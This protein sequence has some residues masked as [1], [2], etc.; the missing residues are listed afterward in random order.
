MIRKILLLALV[1]LIAIQFFHPAKN[2]SPDIAAN[3]IRHAYSVP[4]DVQAIFKKAC[5][6]CHSNNTRYP[7]YYNIQPVA[8][9]IK[10]HVDEGREELDF[11]EFAAYKPKKQHHKLEEL[12]EQ[13]KEEEMPLPSY[14]WIHRNAL[15]TMAE[16]VSITSWAEKLRQQIAATH[17]LQEAA[18]ERH[19]E[20]AGEAQQK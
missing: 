17:N 6:D 10:G 1:A 8:W 12:I 18:Q 16:K 19:N 20:G 4:D 2:Q 3:D 13:V 14:T 9:W 7:W 15:L 11:S 5:N